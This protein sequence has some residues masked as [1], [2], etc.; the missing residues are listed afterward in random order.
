MLVYGAGAAWSRL[1]LQAGAD[2]IWSEPESALEPRTSGAGAAL[3]SGGSVTLFASPNKLQTVS[4]EISVDQ[5]LLGGLLESATWLQIRGLYENGAERQEVR[6]TFASPESPTVPSVVSSISSSQA[7]SAPSPPSR[8]RIRS[9][10]ELQPEPLTSPLRPPPAIY[11]EV[12]G[13][14]PPPAADSP[15]P[16]KVARTTEGGANTRWTDKPHKKKSRQKV[17][18]NKQEHQVQRQAV[19]EPEP[20]AEDH[21]EDEEE[22]E[23]EIDQKNNIPDIPSLLNLGG[24]DFFSHFNADRKPTGQSGPLLDSPLMGEQL[25]QA[26]QMSPYFSQLAAL[27][28]N[29]GQAASFTGTFTSF[30]AEAGGR[31]SS[32][33][34]KPGFLSSAPVRRYK[35]Y[36][37][38]SL[39]AALKEIMAGQSINR[40]SMK[41][42]IPA[43]TLRDWMKRLNIK[44]VYTH[45]HNHKGDK[46]GGGSVG[47]CSPEP[48]LSV[49][50]SE[51]SLGYPGYPAMFPNL[52]RA[53]VG[54]LHTA[55]LDEE[56][57]EEEEE[58]NLKIDESGP[59]SYQK[60]AQ[61]AI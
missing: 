9:S 1:F 5:P 52:L 4:G 43:R 34:L 26:M 13:C 28:Q 38:D 32:P 30:A 40:S 45:H 24:R 15:P 6:E 11:Q 41:H 18:H 19:V 55:D 56:E 14:T 27:Q 48:E 21:E 17:E 20:Q 23:E 35:Q 8:K 47:S 42:N 59:D 54:Q 53:A 31:S 46:D 44:S 49:N 50:L 37:E 7:D 3:K 10:R 60:I 16:G 29:C 12:R 57:E 61:A 51:V 25:L 36:T 33:D 22:E 2:P 39:Q 58:E